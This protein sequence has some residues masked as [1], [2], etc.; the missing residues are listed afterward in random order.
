[1]AAPT[2]GLHFSPELLLALKKRGIGIARL[3]LHVGYGTFAE[4]S[5]KDLAEGR[6]HAEWA[7]LPERAAYAINQARQKGGRIIAVGTTSLRTLEWVARQK[8]RIQA[9]EGWCDLLINEGHRFKAV[10]G[11]MTNF[12]LPRTTLLML[13]SAL[14]G[15]ER[16][17]A[18]Y[19]EAVAGDYRF[20]SFGDAMLLV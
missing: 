2:A 14:A 20:Y 5:P 13:V 16:V 1:V 8:G 15:R 11:L 18:A 12:H 4:P 6:L 3:T 9:H 10:D 19:Q 17:L 7:E